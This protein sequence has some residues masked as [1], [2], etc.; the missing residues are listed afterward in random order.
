METNQHDKGYQGIGSLFN[1]K[2]MEAY[3]QSNPNY[4][5]NDANKT[6][7]MGEEDEETPYD[8]ALESEANKEREQNSRSNIGEKTNVDYNKKQPNPF[9]PNEEEGI[10][11]TR[12]S[13]NIGDDAPEIPYD[14]YNELEDDSDEEA[15]RTN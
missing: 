6:S 13:H 9:D 7:N 1:H 5:Q 2:A 8:A 12:V 11:I 10:P 15:D 4:S 3:N 14:E